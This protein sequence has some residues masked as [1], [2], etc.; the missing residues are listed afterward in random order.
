MI[1]TARDVTD[2]ITATAE[3]ERGNLNIILKSARGRLVHIS[4][5]LAGNCIARTA[6]AEP[7][8]PLSEVSSLVCVNE[9]VYNTVE[10][11]KEHQPTG[12]VEGKIRSNP[13]TIAMKRKKSYS[14]TRL[15]FLLNVDSIW[16]LPCRLL[17]TYSAN[18]FKIKDS[19]IDVGMLLKWDNGC[20][21]QF[22]FRSPESLR[23]NIFV[24]FLLASNVKI[25]SFFSKT[26]N[27]NLFTCSFSVKLFSPTKNFRRTNMSLIWVL[28]KRRTENG[29]ENIISSLLLKKGIDRT[30]TI[31]L[32]I[33]YE[34]LLKF[35]LFYWYP[36]EMSIN[37]SIAFN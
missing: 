27:P 22:I 33:T 2:N 25:L 21:K 11:P 5:R 17:C 7:L 4:Q 36:Y 24:G 9:G 6:K 35:C 20:D 19:Y 12:Q 3:K 32:F 29:R 30:E 37:Y 15:W 26:T 8:T 16:N 14:V 18:G 28:R 23:W 34:W 31:N 1:N 13:E 10:D